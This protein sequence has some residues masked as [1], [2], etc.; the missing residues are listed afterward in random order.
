MYNYIE[1]N[2]IPSPLLP[3]DVRVFAPQALCIQKPLP[4]SLG[5]S[6]PASEGSSKET[7]LL[8]MKVAQDFHEGFCV[9][10]CYSFMEPIPLKHLLANIDLEV[11]HRGFKYHSLF[12]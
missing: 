1:M 7:H 12:L 9:C 3:Q 10:F 11:V 6:S 4:T 2:H 8:C 5:I